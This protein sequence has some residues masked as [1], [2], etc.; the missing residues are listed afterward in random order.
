MRLLLLTAIS[1]SLCAYYPDLDGPTPRT[2]ALAKGIS[3]SR[4]FEEA[5]AMFASLRERGL[6]ADQTRASFLWKVV[7]TELA[8]GPSC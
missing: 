4:S 6:L 5:V 1:T 2:E 7:A 8:I 3:S